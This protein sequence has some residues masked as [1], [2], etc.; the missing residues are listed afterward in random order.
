MASKS[1]EDISIGFKNNDLPKNN[2]SLQARKSVNNPSYSVGSGLSGANYIG[3]NSHPLDKMAA[4]SQPTDSNEFLWMKM[5]V[6][7]SKF[8]WSLFLR[9]Q[10]TISQHWFR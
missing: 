2:C 7:W 1:D 3:I 6:F 8:H 5:F 9:V 4:I 10:L